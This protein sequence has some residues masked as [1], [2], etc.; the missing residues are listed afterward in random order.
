L[1]EGQIPLEEL[2]VRHK[3]SRELEE[4]SVLSS[5]RVVA[6][7]LEAHGKVVRRGQRIRFIYIS[8]GPGVYAWDLPQPPDLRS[9]DRA[10]YRKLLIR[11]I[12][13]VLEPL[14]VTEAILKNWLIGGAGYL[15]PPGLLGSSDPTRLALPLLAEVKHLRVDAI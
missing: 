15:A 2:V 9:V 3:L 1:K 4:Y 6:K 14:G 12:Q 10:K 11:A 7:Q 5:A 13:D 8:P